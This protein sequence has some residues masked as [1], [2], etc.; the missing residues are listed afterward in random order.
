MTDPEFDYL[1]FRQYKKIFTMGELWKEVICVLYTVI[2]LPKHF[3]QR[4][5]KDYIFFCF[6]MLLQNR[7]WGLIHLLL[8]NNAVSFLAFVRSVQ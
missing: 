5:L 6:Y 2:F 4:K 3:I 1:D 7:D 8:L